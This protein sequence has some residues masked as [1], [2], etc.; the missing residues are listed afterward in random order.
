MA[1]KTLKRAGEEGVKGLHWKSRGFAEAYNPLFPQQC[2]GLERLPF[3]GLGLCGPAQL[4]FQLVTPSWGVQG[5]PR[6]HGDGHWWGKGWRCRLC[7]IPLAG[8][9]V[10][11]GWLPRE[12]SACTGRDWGVLG[13]LPLMGGL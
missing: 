13:G 6:P 11:E 10:G 4:C 5:Q 1:V 7:P 8:G 9:C 2:L 3:A 12:R